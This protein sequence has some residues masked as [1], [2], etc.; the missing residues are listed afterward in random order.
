LPVDV[1]VEICTEPVDV[2]TKLLLGEPL[3]FL[4]EPAL[5]SG[6]P[7]PMHRAKTIT[8]NPKTTVR[9]MACINTSCQSTQLSAS[10]RTEK[11]ASLFFLKGLTSLL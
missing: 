10:T 3:S 5:G 8:R 11:S 4:E 9:A 7:A 2:V 1:F 6:H